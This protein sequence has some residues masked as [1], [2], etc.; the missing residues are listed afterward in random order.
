VKKIFLGAFRQFYGVASLAPVSVNTMLAQGHVGF[1]HR[2]SLNHRDHAQVIDSRE[3]GGVCQAMRQQK[4]YRPGILQANADRQLAK[5]CLKMWSFL[6]P[7]FAKRLTSVSLV[8]SF[9]GK[10]AT[11]C[12]IGNNKSARICNHLHVPTFGKCERLKTK[13]SVATGIRDL[14]GCKGHGG[15]KL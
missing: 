11:P 7:V 6:Q 15:R 8:R 5:M 1:L 12:A 10:A 4:T 14:H 9:F 13:N 3:A 2:A